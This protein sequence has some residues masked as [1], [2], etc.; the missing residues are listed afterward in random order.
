MDI[1][2]F[3]TKLKH[4][5]DEVSNLPAARSSKNILLSVRSQP[6][7]GIKTPETLEDSLAQLQLIVKYLIFD[8]EATRRE[9]KYLRKVLEGQED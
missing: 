5:L 8:V 2:A 1:S 7:K 3:E 4:L 6:K 9:N